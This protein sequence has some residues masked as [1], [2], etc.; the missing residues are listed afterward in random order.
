VSIDVRYFS[1]ND[2]DVFCRRWTNRS[3][4][5][6][7]SMF[8]IQ[9]YLEWGMSSIKTSRVKVTCQKSERQMLKHHESTLL[10]LDVAGSLSANNEMML[11]FGINL[12]HTDKNNRSGDLS[13]SASY[14]NIIKARR[15]YLS[16][17][18]VQLAPTQISDEVT[19]RVEKEINHCWGATAK[20]DIKLE[21]SRRDRERWVKSA[22]SKFK[23]F[24]ATQYA[25]GTQH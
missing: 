3:R 20:L 13:T 19:V 16:Q 10:L 18:S 15:I 24:L 8:G 12:T 11:A 25:T 22:S 7:G 23:S 1:I 14:A 6:D 21:W 5:N 17:F 2:S 9:I 4:S